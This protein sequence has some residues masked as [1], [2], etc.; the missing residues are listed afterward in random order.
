[1]ISSQFVSMCP[2]VYTINSLHVACNRS[3][4]S[5]TKSCTSS[6]KGITALTQLVYLSDACR[7]SRT[8]MNS[9]VQHFLQEA[10]RAISAC[11]IFLSNTLFSQSIVEN[12][13]ALRN[14]QNCKGSY[15]HSCNVAQ[16][17]VFLFT[18]STPLRK[19]MQPVSRGLSNSLPF[20]MNRVPQTWHTTTTNRQIRNSLLES[21]VVPRTHQNSRH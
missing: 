9:A 19:H 21:W 15:P 6:G 3:R 14:H 7:P 1:M 13:A 12:L 8:S 16:L 20:F 5:T 17:G 4:R 18:P 10:L 2:R 11:T